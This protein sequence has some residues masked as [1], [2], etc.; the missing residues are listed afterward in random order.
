MMP[1]PL[2]ALARISIIS[3]KDGDAFVSGSFTTLENRY[4]T[5]RLVVAVAESVPLLE[6]EPSV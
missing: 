2:V 1:I 5:S 4:R 3:V 6:S